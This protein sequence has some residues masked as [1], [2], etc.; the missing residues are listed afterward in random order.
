MFGQ[1][2]PML[3]AFIYLIGV[4]PEGVDFVP[5]VLWLS[6]VLYWWAISSSRL[7]SIMPIAKDVIFNSIDDAV[8]VLDESPR[9]VEINEACKMYFPQWHRAHLGTAVQ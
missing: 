8:R 2:V 4:T 7:F 5:M 3:T 6:S 1:F 9:L